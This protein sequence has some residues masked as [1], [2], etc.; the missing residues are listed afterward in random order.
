[1][2]YVLLILSILLLLAGFVGCL[3]PILPGPPLSFAAV[4]LVHFSKFADFTA[5]ELIFLG[6]LAL[7]VQVL[8]F[9]VPAWGTKKFG[10]SRMGTWGAII[11][12]I[13]G[14]FFLPA[15]G[16][17]G[18]FTILGGPFL[19]AYIGEKLEGKN[20]EKA[21]RAAFGSFIGFL[22]GTMM[23]LVASTIIAIYFI[24]EIWSNVF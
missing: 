9:I 10:G 22:A 1:M 8:D 23:K 15:F 20:S 17:F 24:K 5:N 11:G 16:P 19:G 12:L 7:I 18:I 2:D 3:L 4:I 14:L 13:A 21:L 6:L